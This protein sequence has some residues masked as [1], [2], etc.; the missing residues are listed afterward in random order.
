M[1]GRRIWNPAATDGDLC[2]GALEQMA[3]SL[4]NVQVN[5]SEIGGEIPNSITFLDMYGV[6]RPRN[7]MLPNAGSAAVPTKI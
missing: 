7:C 2:S 3:R 5:E 6:S 1:R 4:C